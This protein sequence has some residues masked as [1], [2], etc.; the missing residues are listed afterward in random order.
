MQHH[1]VSYRITRRARTEIRPAKG[2][3]RA[4]RPTA[5]G[6]LAAALVLTLLLAL[7]GAPTAVAQ[8]APLVPVSGEHAINGYSVHWNTTVTGFLPASVIETHGLEPSGRGVLNVVV[9]KKPGAGGIPATTSA[10]ISANVSGVLRRSEPIR[11]RRIEEHG[12]TSYLGTFDVE[13]RERLR[14]E[15]Q[16][17]LPGKRTE[18]IEFQGRFFPE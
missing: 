1:D 16:V 12:R 11:L 6:T 8:D 13:G 4:I 17:K 18:H 3:R 14:F 10:D 9:L 7:G 5:A 15:L 2:R